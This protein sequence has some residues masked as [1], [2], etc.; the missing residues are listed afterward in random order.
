MDG[1][2]E[3]ALNVWPFIALEAMAL[4]DYCWC[5]VSFRFVPPPL[6]SLRSR[7]KTRHAWYVFVETAGVKQPTG[8]P[9][10]GP[11]KALRSPSHPGLELGAICAHPRDGG[12][13]AEWPVDPPPLQVPAAVALLFPHRIPLTPLPPLGVTANEIQQPP[14]FFFF[15]YT[16]V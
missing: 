7:R 3:A 6:P 5:W 1:S 2:L 8:G 12:P 10:C 14:L 13:V 11:A 15:W 4:N 9:P 16:Y